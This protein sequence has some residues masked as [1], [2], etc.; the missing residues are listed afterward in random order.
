M[1]VDS[2][3]LDRTPGDGHGLLDWRVGTNRLAFSR[4]AARFDGPCRW[5]EERFRG[6]G[7]RSDARG[8]TSSTFSHESKPI[9]GD[10]STA[11]SR[12]GDTRMQA[13]RAVSGAPSA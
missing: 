11:E 9:P 8:V 10:G 7:H 5:I 4:K 2:R 13:I 12:H 1:I 3:R 6:G